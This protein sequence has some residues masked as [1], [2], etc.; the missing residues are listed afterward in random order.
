MRRDPLAIGELDV[1]E[2]ALVAPD[3][4]ALGDRLLEAHAERVI[5]PE[6]AAGERRAL[7]RLAARPRIPP[8]PSLTELLDQSQTAQRR[9]EQLKVS[10]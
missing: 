7:D 4:A 2:E 1:G 5:A 9:F 6:P 3:Q 8:M 10:L